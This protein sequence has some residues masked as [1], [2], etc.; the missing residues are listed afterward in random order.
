MQEETTMLQE[1]E[2]IQPEAKA[3]QLWL[4]IANIID[5]EIEQNNAQQPKKGRRKH[6]HE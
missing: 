5:K 4:K 6:R 2:T 3:E 1:E